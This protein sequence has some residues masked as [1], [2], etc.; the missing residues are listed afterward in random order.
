MSLAKEEFIDR[1]VAYYL[2]ELH[3]QFQSGTLNEDCVQNADETHFILNTDFGKAS[4]FKRSEGVKWSD[5][6]YGGDGTKMA[7][8]LSGSRD[9]HIEP[10][11]MIFKNR[12][13]NYPVRGIPDTVPGV[14]YRTGPQG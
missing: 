2:G 13:W 4:G 12:V 10:A 14:E 1:E 11:V 7:V 8:R 6:T 9:A 5:V 3:R